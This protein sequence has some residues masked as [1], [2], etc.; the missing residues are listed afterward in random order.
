MPTT[1]VSTIETNDSRLRRGLDLRAGASWR[2][3]WPLDT[4]VL[5]RIRASVSPST[6][7]IE[8][9][10][11]PSVH[12]LLETIARRRVIDVDRRLATQRERT[13]LSSEDSGAGRGGGRL[14]SGRTGPLTALLRAE[15]QELCRQAFE[16]LPTRAKEILQL[17]LVEERSVREISKI[18]DKSVGAVWVW[19]H[20]AL[21][22][23]SAN[24]NQM[25]GA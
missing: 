2:A 18:T 22:A 15:E 17:R 9:Q 1:G 4:L 6:Y 11:V 7:S 13:V 5:A 23:W 8:Y 12:R 19:F 14:D 25:R 21:R 3:T 10:G 24:F 16:K 20:R